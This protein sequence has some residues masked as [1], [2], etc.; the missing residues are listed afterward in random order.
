MMPLFCPNCRMM[1]LGLYIG[2]LLLPGVHADDAAVQAREE[3]RAKRKEEHW[4]KS[5][6]GCPLCKGKQVLAC[7][8]PCR[9]KGGGMAEC[10]TGCMTN[11]PLVLSMMLAMVP[12]EG[13]KEASPPAS[14]AKE[15]EIDD[16]DVLDRVRV[17]AV[18]PGRHSE[19]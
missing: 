17:D 15:H 1:I 13:K 18:V 16:S 14:Q 4:L 11:N 2:V 3:K 10:L 5:I 12:E 8:T 7:Y 19:L 6:M 9:E